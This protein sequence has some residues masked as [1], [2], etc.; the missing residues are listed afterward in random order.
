MR[1]G[2]PQSCPINL[3]KIARINLW[4]STDTGGLVRLSYAND[5]GR[6]KTTDG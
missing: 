6:T 1:D 4:L 5:D 2:L 3:I